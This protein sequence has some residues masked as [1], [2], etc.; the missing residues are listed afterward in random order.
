GA[1]FAVTRAVVQRGGATA[2]RK[3]TGEWPG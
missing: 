3:I 1:I 2:A